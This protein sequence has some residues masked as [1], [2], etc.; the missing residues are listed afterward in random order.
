VQWDGTKKNFKKLKWEQCIGTREKQ[1]M[2]LFV[3]VKKDEYVAKTVNGT[4]GD[5]YHCHTNHCD[6]VN[7]DKYKD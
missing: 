7:K 2:I 6:Y 5:N 1:E 4:N 3:E